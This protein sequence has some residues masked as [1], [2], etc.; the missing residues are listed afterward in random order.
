MRRYSVE[1]SMID[2]GTT[3]PALRAALV[4]GCDGANSTVRAGLGIRLE[5]RGTNGYGRVL[6]YEWACG[7]GAP[8][9]TA[10][11]GSFFKD[12]QQRP[13]LRRMLDYTTAMKALSE[14]HPAD[15]E[16]GIFY[17][18]A[19]GFIGGLLPALRA[20]RLPIPAALREL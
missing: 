20:A 7:S 4:I 18:L 2:F 12:P 13:H 9:V 6:A 16:A 14:R 1:M 8:F 10:A 19:M 17:A 5:G 11:A 15:R 3:K